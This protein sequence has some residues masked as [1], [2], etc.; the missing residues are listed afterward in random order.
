MPGDYIGAADVEGR[1]VFERH[2]PEFHYGH[3]CTHPCEDV[4]I[5][6]GLF[7]PNQVIKIYY[8]DLDLH[9]ALTQNVIVQSDSA[10]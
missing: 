4:M 2:Y 8:T 6:D 3:M 9:G 1:T 10:L 7:T 5:T